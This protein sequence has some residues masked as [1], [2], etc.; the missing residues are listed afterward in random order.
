MDLDPIEFARAVGGAH[1]STDGAVFSMKAGYLGTS[2]EV[3]ENLC[4]T[5]LALHAQNQR[6]RE[7]LGEALPVLDAAHDYANNNFLGPNGVEDLKAR[8]FTAVRIMD[9]DDEGFDR[10]FVYELRKLVAVK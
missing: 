1:V 9:H 2:W 10:N 7:A 4:N 8:L 6:L 5:V 3:M